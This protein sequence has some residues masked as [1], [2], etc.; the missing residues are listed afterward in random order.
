M[1]SGLSPSSM[2]LWH[3]CPRRFEREKV[4]RLPSDT[5]VPAVTGTLVHR[6]LEFL[7]EL[8]PEQ[9]TQK[10]AYDAL[11]KAWPETEGGAEV[12]QLGLSKD[13]LLAMRRSAVSSMRT[14]FEV[15]DPQAVDVVATERKLGVVIDPDTLDA[16]PMA[17][18]FP[19]ED[20]VDDGDQ[21]VVDVEGV[22]LRGIID[23]LDRNK[24]GQLVITDYKNGKVPLPRYQGPKLRQLNIYGALVEAVDGELPR[25][26]RLV[27]TAYGQEI[28][29]PIS[30]VSVDNAKGEAV[31][32]W[33]EI[34]A[35]YESG[36][37]APIPGPLCGWCPFAA[38]CTEGIAELQ[39]R[40]R[41]GRLKRA[42]PNFALSEPG[43]VPL[44]L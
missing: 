6:A 32:V 35:A 19:G 3:Q 44:P 17:V 7:L 34:S 9:R 8:P 21:N 13:E 27:F 43:V 18:A 36:D 39:Q 1:P 40:R 5:G 41:A 23:R 15:E 30:R 10:A 31:R 16:T 37:F 29:T 12:Q 33:G 42:A 2:E 14:Y 20:A 26:G 11:K 22:P 28:R 24:H 4:D 25:H 38:E